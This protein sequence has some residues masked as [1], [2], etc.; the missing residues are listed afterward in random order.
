MELQDVE[1]GKE[2][3]IEKNDLKIPILNDTYK[4][5]QIKRQGKTFHRQRVPKLSCRRKETV[6]IELIIT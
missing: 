6:G 5:I 3:T 2:K 1:G 4:L